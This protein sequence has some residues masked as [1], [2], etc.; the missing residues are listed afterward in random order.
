MWRGYDETIVIRYPPCRFPG[1]GFR[2]LFR[3]VA[4]FEA[5]GA[6]VFGGWTPWFWGREKGG[7]KSAHDDLISITR[8]L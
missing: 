8:S 2:E 1:V 4:G 6:R 3:F 5:A 7:G